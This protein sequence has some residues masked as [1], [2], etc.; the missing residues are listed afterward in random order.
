MTML[1]QL[2][3]F[4]GNG[5][6]D[7][8]MSARTASG[9]KA[10]QSAATRLL[11]QFSSILLGGL[12]L[13]THALA[14]PFQG[15]PLPG[16]EAGGGH[17]SATT[18]ITPDNVK[19]L[20]IVWTH[21]SGDFSEGD[22]FIG[23][24]SGEAPLQSSWQATPILIDDHLYLCTPFNR[25]LAIHAETGAES[26]SYAPDIDLANFPMPR[27]RGVTQWTDQR[28]PPTEP[29]H[30]VVVAPLMD[31]RVVGL[32][33]VT[34]QICPFG[35]KTELDLSEGLG[36]YQAGFYM[37]NTPPAIA[38]NA[39]ITGGSVADNMTTAVP[40]GVVRAYDLNSGALLWA[41]EPVVAVEKANAVSAESPAPDEKSIS[42]D[43]QLYQQGTT[44]SWSYL[45]VDLEL[46]L[47]Y[48]PTGNTSPDYY[49]GHRGNLDHYS[50]SVVALKIDTGEVA[51]HFQT[52]HHDIWD[53]DVPSQPT[54]FETQIEGRDV[55]GLAQTT[56][57]GYVFLLDRETGEPLFPVKEVP[58][59]QGTAPG[60]YTSP[61]QPVPTAPRSLLDLPGE[62][63]PI[64]GLVPW[65]KWACQNTLDN[66]RYEGPF[67]PPALEG[68]LHMPSA[69]GGQNWG[70][71]AIDPGRQKLVVNTLHMGTVV[72]LI[73]RD[74]CEG[75][76]PEPV[77]DGPFLLE[78]SEG[79][80]YC[81]RRWLGFVSPMGVPCTPPP[82]GTLAG[83][84]L[85]TGNVDWQ[86]PL[87]TTRD[88]APWPFW[89]IKGSPNLGGPVSTAGGLTF[90]GATT[91]HFLRAFDTDTGEE[92]WKGR[93]PTSGHG[94]PI[95]YQLTEGGKQY[96]V[97]AAGGHAAMGTPPGDYLIAFALPE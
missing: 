69:F 57:Q 45:S 1:L 37:L 94:L 97:I 83:I 8:K 42:A 96:V 5:T 68:A 24:L 17:F 55:K 85:Q 49:G 18:Q 76:G 67:T 62:R 79:T 23:G 73:P 36:P 71:P 38:G 4:L 90:I 75:E 92:L 14:E 64:W 27:C 11:A 91:D 54:L 56:K 48:V 25:I 16:A 74:Q 47:V 31:A 58:M 13:S 9:S 82:W 46:G 65:D 26:W 12:W 61:T 53:F 40:S 95:T 60:D 6:S 52:V 33:A 70:G 20:E 19:D 39:L 43:D 7:K 15:W 32:D 63:D 87:G 30:R 59:P 51:W 93:L 77:A 78:P 3:G 41:W 89:Y 10:G 88:M 28:I 44:N 29:C 86:V 81:N 35:N 66:L 72:Q 34:G 2:R 80:P 22:N 21:R 50:S 84:D